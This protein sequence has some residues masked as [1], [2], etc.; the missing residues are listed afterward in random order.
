MKWQ[1]RPCS[2]SDADAFIARVHSHHGPPLQ[3][4]F[5]IGAYLGDDLCGVVVVER[6]KARVLDDGWTLEVSRL[7]CPGTP[8]TKGLA[9][10]L[11][12][13]AWR[14]AHAMG[15][16]TLVSYTR[17]DESG[18]CYAAAGWWP[19]ARVTGREWVTGNKSQR[20][21]PGLYVPTTEVVDRIRWEKT[22]GH[23]QGSPLAALTMFARVARP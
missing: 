13:R 10:D 5:R 11:L 8:E 19:V 4:V 12:G 22:A 14:A 21:L 17:V 1:V 2:K 15:V 16:S 18:T 9:S 3:A 6:P 20:W 7:C 23:R